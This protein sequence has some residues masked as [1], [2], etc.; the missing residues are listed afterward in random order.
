MP[1]TRHVLIVDDHTDV[2]TLL[3]RLVAQCWPNA[4]IDAAA[5]GAAALSMVAQQYPDLIITD[6]Q[7][8]IV[9]GLE[10]ICTLRTRGATMPILVISSDLSIA[11]AI[12]AAGASAFLPKPFSVRALR[13]LL[14]MLLP[15]DGETR[16]V[17][18]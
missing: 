2:R 9:G 1:P 16:A 8:P 14:R 7:M 4:T 15:S 17:G 3:A 11:E 13:E 12:R 6:Y 18:E 5:N 10:L